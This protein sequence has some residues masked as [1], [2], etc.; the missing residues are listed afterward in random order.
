VL[1]PFSK[2]ESHLVWPKHR[3]TLRGFFGLPP[4]VVVERVKI[5]AFSYEEMGSYGKLVLPNQPLLIVLENKTAK[6]QS[7][8]A[9]T[10]AYE[11]IEVAP[12]P[13]Q[14]KEESRAPEPREGSILL[15]YTL[16]F[17]GGE[18]RAGFRTQEMATLEEV[19]TSGCT[20]KS[21]SI[22][23]ALFEGQSL[24]A[25]R[26]M[27]IAEGTPI[28]IVFTPKGAITRAR[29]IVRLE[30]LVFPAQGEG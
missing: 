28:E 3:I 12:P 5:G 21:V 7:L 2:T 20:L 14:T 11:M 25:W 30:R 1:A 13:V 4:G 19:W 9:S 26:G 8:I 10:L 18:A 16:L 24:F 22:M 17:G 15:P 27:V 23:N 29:A 6:P